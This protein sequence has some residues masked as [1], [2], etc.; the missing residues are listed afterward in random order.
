MTMGIDDNKAEVC[1]NLSSNVKM[2][3]KINE[4][5]ATVSTTHCSSL[6]DPLTTYDSCGKDEPLPYFVLAS[7]YDTSFGR[8]YL[9]QEHNCSHCLMADHFLSSSSVLSNSLLYSLD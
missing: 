2:E 6:G 5:G 4:L 9:L 8:S 7:L 1:F 3:S